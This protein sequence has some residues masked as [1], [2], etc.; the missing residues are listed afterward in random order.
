MV[1]IKRKVEM[2]PE[3]YAKHMIDKHGVSGYESELIDENI[4][5]GPNRFALTFEL[6]PVSKKDL[7]GKIFWD[8]KTTVEV[9]EEI[10]EDTKFK[11]LIEIEQDDTCY[12]WQNTSVSAEK[13]VSDCKNISKEF[14]AYIDGDFKCIWRD[15][16]LVE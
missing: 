8:G 4:I 5:G 11:T 10:T 16:K 6:N 13:Q 14:H 7:V 12:M 1:K 2:T 9:E 15:G 3:E